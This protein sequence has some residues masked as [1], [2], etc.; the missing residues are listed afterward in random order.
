[1]GFNFCSAWRHWITI[2]SGSF[3]RARAPIRS[4]GP[5]WHLLG[6]KYWDWETF[7]D[8]ENE[9]GSEM[10]QRESNNFFLISGFIRTLPTVVFAL[11]LGGELP[12][13][14]KFFYVSCSGLR[15]TLQAS[16]HYDSHDLSRTTTAA[17]CQK[18]RSLNLF[19]PNFLSRV[20]SGFPIKVFFC[21][22]KSSIPFLSDLSLKFSFCGTGL[23][24]KS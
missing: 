5:Q 1:M 10:V 21:K 24:V 3:I 9:A 12:V 7:Q 2:P 18:L 19:P 4:S 8:C 6:Q 23:T 16:T 15:H 13:A 11:L 17:W 22:K 20:K 14:E